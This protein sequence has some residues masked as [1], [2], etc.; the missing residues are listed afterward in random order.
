MVICLLIDHHE[1][2]KIKLL[3]I[4]NVENIWLICVQ[5]SNALVL[6]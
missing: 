3:S 2:K 1:V 5:Q 4:A 6:M